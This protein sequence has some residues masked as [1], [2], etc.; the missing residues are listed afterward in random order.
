M[1]VAVI[2]QK[3][4][5]NIAKIIITKTDNDNDDDDEEML[6]C[7]H[8]QQWTTHEKR[9]IFLQNFNV[10]CTYSMYTRRKK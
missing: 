1:F 8:T 3:I 6:I 5:N 10:P 4:Q 9:K 2:N 7:R